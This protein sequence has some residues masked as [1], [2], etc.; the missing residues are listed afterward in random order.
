MDGNHTIWT[1]IPQFRTFACG[2]LAFFATILGREDSS[3]CNCPYCS[4][5]AKQWKT[6]P[7]PPSQKIT[8][9]LLIQT[10]QQESNTL[11]VKQCPQWTAIEVHHYIVPILHLQMG[12]VNLA[13]NK[14][15]SFI[16]EKIE[17][18]CDKENLVR[19]Y[20]KENIQQFEEQKEEYN[21]FER[22]CEMRLQESDIERQELIEVIKDAQKNKTQSEE[23]ISLWII[24]KEE[25]VNVKKRISAELKKKNH[26]LL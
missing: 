18:V 1:I 13:L 6:I 22:T 5:K 23:V 19:K 7:L 2:D 4:L 12:I 26:L 16:D 3:T 11:A 24:Q 9:E 25:C 20:L 14:L 17:K 10:S 21:M 8:I 15:I